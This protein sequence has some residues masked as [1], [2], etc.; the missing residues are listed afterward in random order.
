MTLDDLTVNISHLK[1]ERLL[2]DWQWLLPPSLSPI[3]ITAVG[4]A[5]MQDKFSG[6]IS[7]LDVGSADILSIAGSMTQ[8]SAL[9]QQRQFV[10]SFFNVS[11]FVE[12]QKSISLPSGMLYGFK[13]L[14]ALGGN[15]EPSNF[16]PTDIEVHFSLCGQLQGKIKNLPPGTPI[17]AVS[18][19]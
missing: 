12:L 4:N 11:L 13:K 3:L 9:I 1:K 16:Q 10:L 5:F 14:P 7:L 17:G 6:T 15:H 18:I 19:C 2:S 8:F